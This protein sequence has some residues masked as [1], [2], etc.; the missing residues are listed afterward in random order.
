MPRNHGSKPSD[1]IIGPGQVLRVKEDDSG[2]E[3]FTPTTGGAHTH[4]E[5]EV[6]NLQTD[7]GSKANSTHT[8]LET[9]IANLVTDL[10]GKESANSNIQIHVT[11]A[12]APSNAQ[13]NSDITKT[14]IEAKLTGEINT[15][16]HAGGS[17]GLSHGQVMS[18][19]FLGV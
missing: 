10:T 15:H 1:L 2:W 18:R 14:E 13:K 9:E 19:V 6:V 17:G 12:H 16:T 8:H 5:S 3:A 7:L 11:S 4:S